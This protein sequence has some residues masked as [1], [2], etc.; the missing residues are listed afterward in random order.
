MGYS[1]LILFPIF[2]FLTNLYFKRQ[3]NKISEPLLAKYH[4]QGYWIKVI[5]CIA[6]TVYSGYLS[7]GDSIGLYQ[8]E[9]VNIYHLILHDSA[10]LRWLWEPGKNFDVSLAADPWNKGYFPA[11]ANYMVIRAVAM[12]SFFTFGSY[13][14]NNLIFACL[15]FAGIWKL[16]LFFYKQKPQLHYSFAIAIIY[17]PTLVFWSSGVMKEPICI[18]AL[19]YIT[20][21]TYSLFCEKRRPVRN[22][23]WIV[24][25]A[26]VLAVVKVYILISYLPFFVLFI[27]LKNVEGIKSGLLRYIVG[28][29]FIAGCLYGFTVVM[30]N[31]Q[32]ELGFYA[33]E[34]LA[35]SIQHLNENF[36]ARDGSETAESNFEL[37]AQ[38]DGTSDGLVKIAP[39]AVFTTFYRPF[40]WES[41]KVSSLLASLEGMALLFFTLLIFCK[42]G[43]VRLFK[44][45]FTDPL[46]LYCFMFSILFA[47]FIGASTLNFGTL[48]RYK[49]PCL[50]FYVIFLILLYEK[51]KERAARKKLMLAATAPETEFQLTP[52]IPSQA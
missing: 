11:E 21:C 26:Y 41:K 3:R 6:F 51:V 52:A 32:E 4:I 9:G 40:I 14:A 19:A 30:D 50:P 31:Y 39:Y 44:Y 38:F 7:P 35:E 25:S 23:L 18:A 5:S 37:G 27:I 10:N 2:L 43:I 16:F 12:I 29:I 15:A 34:D 1:D 17:F 33:V 20:Y 22:G 24:I 45:I 28:P 46:V 47:T 42:T 13:A 36:I 49:I 8:K 48:V